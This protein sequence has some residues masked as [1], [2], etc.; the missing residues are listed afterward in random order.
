MIYPVPT[1]K[2]VSF[3]DPLN[4]NKNLFSD[5][6]RNS[7]DQEKKQKNLLSIQS[8]QFIVNSG[9]ISRNMSKKQIHEFVQPVV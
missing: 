8:P 9:L 1:N 5:E 7:I 4:I 3:M 6:K 2:D